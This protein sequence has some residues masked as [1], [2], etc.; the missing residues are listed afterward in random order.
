MTELQLEFIRKFSPD[1]NIGNWCLVIIEK[2]DSLQQYV[3]GDDLNSNQETTL[4]VSFDKNSIHFESDFWDSGSS[5]FD[6]KI[7]EVI[8]YPRVEWHDVFARLKEM[9]YLMTAW[10][11]QI[12]FYLHPDDT[13]DKIIVCDLTLSPM[14]QPEL[15]EQLLLLSN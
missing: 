10:Y 2:D 12:T 1:K 3:L 14:E 9:R 15:I 4:P 6:I 5:Y 8:G 7:V 11:W 13:M